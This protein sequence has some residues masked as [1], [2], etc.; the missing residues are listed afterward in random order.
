MARTAIFQS[1]QSTKASRYGIKSYTLC[2]SATGFCFNMRPYVG[3]ASALSETVFSLLDRLP[4]PGY[5]LYMDNFYNSVALCE[6][7]LGAQTNV[8]GTLRKNRGEPKLI[9]DVTKTD[10]AVGDSVMRHNDRVMVV[11]WRDQ[12]LVKMVTTCHQDRMQRVEVWQKGEKNKV[13]QFKQECVIDY[14]SCMNGV[15]KLDQNI[16]YF[17]FI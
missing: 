2:D 3:E 17:P 6:R 16:A 4:H 15:D 9:S 10:L 14:N 5:T 12:R 11:A 13:P 8:C 7:L 1:V